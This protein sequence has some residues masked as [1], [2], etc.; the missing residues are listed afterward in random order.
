MIPSRL[1]HAIGEKTGTSS[2]MFM[3]L[4]NEDKEQFTGIYVVLFFKKQ[5]GKLVVFEVLGLIFLLRF[6][7]KKKMMAKLLRQLKVKS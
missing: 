6:F 1:T 7:I 2:L 4:R 3:G 5:K